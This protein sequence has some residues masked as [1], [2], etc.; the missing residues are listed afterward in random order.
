MKRTSL[1]V[2]F[3][4]FALSGCMATV[5]TRRVDL[6]GPPPPAYY[7]YTYPGGCWADDL[8]YAPCPWA[9]GPSYGYYGW[10]GGA[11]RWHPEYR[12][13]SRPGSPSPRHWR[14]PPLPPRPYHPARPHPGPP[15]RF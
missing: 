5:T 2:L 9:P 14:Q 1:A 12:G 11:Y 4:A 15:R 10:S 6:Y 3:L 7:V 13:G 8:W